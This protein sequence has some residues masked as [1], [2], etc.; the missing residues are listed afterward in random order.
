MNIK[1]DSLTHTQHM[2]IKY[3]YCIRIL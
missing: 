3:V 1:A 2:F